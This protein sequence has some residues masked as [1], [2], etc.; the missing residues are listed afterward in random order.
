MKILSILTYYHPH[1]TGLTRHAVWLAEEMAHEGHDVTVL[2]T[3]H[4]KH[5][6]RQERVNGVRVVRL[7][8]LLQVSRGM[9]SLLFPFHAA[10]LIRRSDVVQ[11]HTPLPEC[12][13]VAWL[14]RLMG[15]PLVMTHHGDFTPPG[16]FWN[17]LLEATAFVLSSAAA[18]SCDAITSYSDDYTAESRLLRAHRTRVVAVRPPVRIPLPAPG[19][20][21]ALRNE[22]G[23]AGKRLIGISGRW[24]MEK[25]FD[26]L[27]RAMPWIRRAVPEAHLVFAGE[28]RVVHDPAWRQWLPL[29]E[30][31]R[32]HMTFAG[33]IEDRARLAAFYSML[34]VLVLPSHSEMMGIVQVE[35]MLCGTPVV[36]TDVPGART[37]VRETGFGLIAPVAD[38]SALA[39][40]VVQVLARPAPYR[41]RVEA[42]RGLYDP[43]AAARATLSLME[44]AC[45]PGGAA[46]GPER[47]GGQES[48]GRDGVERLLEFEPDPAF[49]RRA[50]ALLELLQ[51]RPG[52]HVL[53]CGCGKGFYTKALRDLFQCFAVGVDA[54]FE[55][56]AAARV[57][58]ACVALASA[59]GRRLPFRDGAF[60]KVLLTEV[61]EHLDDDQTVLK[62]CLRVLRPKG[63]LAVSVPC[64]RY[65]FLWDPFNRV[66]TALGGAPLRSGP[67]VGIWTRHR[68]L[69]TAGGLRRLVEGAG[70]EVEVEQRAT[71]YCLPF[72]HFLLYGVGK[73]LVERGWVPAAVAAPVDRFSD[74]PKRV[75]RWSPLGLLLGATRWV[76]AFNDR[77]GAARRKT[78]V[79]LVLKARKPVAAVATS[80]CAG[81]RTSGG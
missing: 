36:A 37:V 16:G 8:C 48:A 49:R 10:R 32:D 50:R 67:V 45:G 70:F 75:G 47:A 68:R 6:P 44:K 9:I 27:L 25:A 54:S 71:H 2:T 63:V 73:P 1:W 26:D 42:V 20:A 12:L 69:Y 52:E 28:T 74:A 46:A 79:N 33:L 41:P 56:L 30:A 22:L 7:G 62:E 64:T 80:R 21:D 51:P 17:R 18:R 59:D 60:E 3:R 43:G 72:S 11:I 24:V 35:A 77:P 31:E 29:V 81:G 34:D 15:R 19:S 5:L 66:W 78:C 58:Q 13:L 38:P 55:D 65:P 57:G 4:L 61:L 53:D 40:A 39:G 23:L 76:D 14:C